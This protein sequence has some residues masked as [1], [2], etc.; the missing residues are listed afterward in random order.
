MHQNLQALMTIASN[1]QNYITVH[2]AFFLPSLLEEVYLASK[3]SS[4][5]WEK[6]AYLYLV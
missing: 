2:T 4:S 3:I 1:C 5:C 6:Y